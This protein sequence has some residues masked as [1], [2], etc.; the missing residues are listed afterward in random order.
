M[1]AKMILKGWELPEYR[2]HWKVSGPSD[3]VLDVLRRCK[4]WLSHSEHVIE[5]CD[6][7]VEWWANGNHR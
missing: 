6:E 4:E 5:L 7:V 2:H 1:E 3:Q